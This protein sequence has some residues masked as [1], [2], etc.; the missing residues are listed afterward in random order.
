[1]SVLKLLKTLQPQLTHKKTFKF[2][3]FNK[4]PKRSLKMI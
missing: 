4:E 3:D 1:M 2:S